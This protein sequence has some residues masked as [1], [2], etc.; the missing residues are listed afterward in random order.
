MAMD[1]SDKLQYCKIRKPTY[2][3]C[4]RVPAN[5]VTGVYPIDTG[6]NLVTYFRGVS[7]IR[8]EMCNK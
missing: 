4:K 6:I 5:H 8:T 7:I 3:T 2:A 1:R